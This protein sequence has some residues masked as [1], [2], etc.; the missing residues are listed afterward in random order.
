[1]SSRRRRSFVVWR[2]RAGGTEASRGDFSGRVVRGRGMGGWIGP[3]QYR[4]VR[5]LRRVILQMKREEF[6][7]SIA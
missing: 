5:Q 7:S 4:L 1:M 6:K 2:G 3:K